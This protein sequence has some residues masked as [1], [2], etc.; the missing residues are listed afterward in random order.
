MTDEDQFGASKRALPE[1][2]SPYG[3]GV[4]ETSEWVYDEAASEE[5]HMDIVYEVARRPEGSDVQA[6]AE[7][8]RRLNG[9]DDP[10]A[11]KIVALHRDCGPGTGECGRDDDDQECV[12]LDWPC[13]TLRVVADHFGIAHPSESSG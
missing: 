1:I 8:M 13:E 6:W 9:I 11:R 4:N 3:V 10:L 12:G 2:R 5:Q 7:S